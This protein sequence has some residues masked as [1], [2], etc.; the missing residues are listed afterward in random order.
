[1]QKLVPMLS[2]ITES[3]GSVKIDRLTVIG[4]G[5]AGGGNLAGQLVST[6]EQIQAATGI[7]VP[8]MLKDRFG[9][10]QA[11]R[12]S[13]GPPIQPARPITQPPPGRLPPGV[14]GGQ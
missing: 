11:P 3:M 10:P 14:R 12:P 4:G 7:D 1:M 5:N 9:R 13:S 2:R 8:Q 6:T